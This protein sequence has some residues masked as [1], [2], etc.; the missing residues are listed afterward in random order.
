MIMLTSFGCQHSVKTNEIIRTENRLFGVRAENG[1]LLID[2]VY[3]QIR[4]LDNRAK[5]TLPPI[6]S[7]QSIE[8]LEYYIVSGT[9][10]R[11][12]IFDKNGKIFFDFVDCA[13]LQFD[14]HTQSVVTVIKQADHRQ[15]SYLYNTKGELQFETSF[16]D[17]GF[18]SHSDLIALIVEQGSNDEFYL[19]SPFTKKK[20]GPIDHFNIFNKDM[21]TF[22][23]EE[24]DLEK[25]QKLNIV[26]VR[27]EVDNEYVWGVI[28]ASGNEILPIEFINL[29]MITTKD[30]QHPAFKRATKP[31][32]VDFIFSGK[33]IS[34]PSVQIYF[35]ENFVKY[36]FK[37]SPRK[38][39]YKI[40]KVL[41]LP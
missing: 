37:I 41:N 33:Q 20:L 28:D 16:E 10:G 31:A 12:A 22:M 34:N 14:E 26:T 4:V 32:G 24:S 36:E 27:K 39:E 35:D 18:I 6:E 8:V 11:K 7:P 30:K 5:L 21:S 3:R 2:T 13:A 15:R 1:H 23:M 17:I 9:S 29:R 19:Y 38:G 25:F 40:E